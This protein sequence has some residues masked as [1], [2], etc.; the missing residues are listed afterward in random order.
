MVKK[1]VA[2]NKS[3]CNSTF[4]LVLSAI[5][6]IYI[7]DYINPTLSTILKVLLILVFLTTLAMY[8]KRGIIS[9]LFLS[10]GLFW[11]ILAF[12]TVMNGGPFLL[13]FRSA[14]S[15][16]QL[17]MITEMGFSTNKK[18]L[19]TVFAYVFGFMALANAISFFIFFSPIESRRGMF[20]DGRK[21]S[22]YYLL[23]QDNG[24]IFYALPAI[25]YVSLLSIEKNKKISYLTFLFSAIIGFS[26]LY[27][28]SGNGIVALILIIIAQA[29]VNSKINRTI[30]KRIDIWKIMI[31]IAAFF[32]IIVL[33]R[34]DNVVADLIAETL[35]K[36]TTFTGR[37]T[38]WDTVISH[39][40]KR[41]L[42]GYGFQDDALRNTMIP[43]G[44]AHNAFLQLC[45][46]GGIVCLVMFVVIIRS[47][48]GHIHDY[49][50]NMKIKSILLYY[51]AIYLIV[52][53]FDFYIHHPLTFVPVMLINQYCSGRIEPKKDHERRLHA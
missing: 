18:K 36:D 27:V 6:N 1:E 11:L 25:L 41:P 2:N 14:A 35:G 10:I 24:T 49:D 47:F 38:I 13:L 8:I 9:K 45:Y 23:G 48:F 32:A 53:N 43:F 7:P 52:A 33:L 4:F 12:S 15:S 19:L 3:I 21:D 22:N 46:N 28:S 34:T 5:S 51:M 50:G 17:C 29:L 26:Y 16:L 37:T 30:F 44:K 42:F 20:M 39:I 40:S 31:A